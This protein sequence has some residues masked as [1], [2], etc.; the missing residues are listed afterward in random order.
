MSEAWFAGVIG[1]PTAVELLSYAVQRQR[2]APAY[3]FVGAEGVGRALT[4]RHFLQ[5][6]L[7]QQPSAIA[8]LT[9][10]PDVLWVEPTYSHQGTLYTRA[11]LMAAGK[12]IPRGTAQIRLEQIRYL[13]RVLSQ[14]PMHAP[15][16]LVV[17][18]QAQTL[19]EA[20]ANALLKTLEEPGRATL[21]L[22][23]PSEASVLNTIVSRCQKIPFTPLRRTD[24]ETVLQRVAPASFWQEVTPE[25]WHLGA[26]SP[27][28]MLH[29]WQT[30]QQIPEV[31]RTLGHQLTCPMPL[32]QC[33]ELARDLSQMLEVERQVWLLS[34]MQQQCWRV[35]SQQGNWAAAMSALRHLEQAQQYL[36]QYVQPRLVWEVLLMQLRA[37]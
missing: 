35:Y 4:A 6:L 2:L 11:Q 8:N 17:I 7:G 28:A 5:I 19:N 18:E 10:H 27:G 26:G 33:L 25:L 34:L 32:R 22:I 9:N 1:Q 16:S 31:F 12:D 20:A 13:S 23:A 14:P 29:A 24:L 36:Q 37:L 30:W 21:I 15:R 3:L